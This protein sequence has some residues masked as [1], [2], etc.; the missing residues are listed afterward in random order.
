MFSVE[1]MNRDDFG[2]LFVV[3]FEG[4]SLS[5]SLK[6]FLLELKPAGVILFARNIEGPVQVS[7][8]NRDLQ[9][10]AMDNWTSVLLI[11]VDQEGGRVRRLRAPFV[12][13][14]S[15]RTLGGDPRAHELVRSYMTIAAHELKLVGFNTNFVPV[16]DVLS[17][18]S[19]SATSV[20]GDRSFGDNP[21]AVARLGR[22]VIQSL[23]SAG[24][25]ACGKHYPG[26]GGTVVDSHVE[27]PLDARDKKSLR[28]K[29]LIPFKAAIDSGVDMMMTAHV[30]YPALDP[31][32]PATLSPEIVNDMLRSE[33]GYN[34]VV[35]TD[36]LDMGAI[37]NHYN[38]AQSAE[39]ALNAGADLLLFSKS[40]DEVLLA[41]KAIMDSIDMESL[42]LDRIAQ[43][44]RRTRRLKERYAPY[45]TPPDPDAVKS[46]FDV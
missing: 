37:T 38:A 10:L 36:D 43:A 45:L 14:P 20:I 17:G 24:V 28:E 34:G 2:E 15:A 40:K 1:H 27:L 42:P 4:T 29:D 26:H 46:H 11:G 21:R 30:M 6:R 9:L 19:G 12:S 8:L 18:H 3:G 13:C 41:R 35:I 5:D 39:L 22:I 31:S 32:L 23:R 16:L 44:L 7:A 25:I 33:L